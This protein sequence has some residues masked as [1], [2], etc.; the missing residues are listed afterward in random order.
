M[1]GQDVVE[2][3]LEGIHEFHGALDVRCC[4]LCSAGDLVDHHVGV[5]K[6]EAFSLGSC[7]KKDRSHGGTDAD[8]VGVHITGE[9]LHGIVDRES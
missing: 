4:S 9:E 5:R 8:A 6:S 7:R 1:V 2:A 3:T